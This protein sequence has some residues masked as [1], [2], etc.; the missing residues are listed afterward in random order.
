MFKSCYFLIMTLHIFDEWFPAEFN[1]KNCCNI[2]ILSKVIANIP[3]RVGWWCISCVLPGILPHLHLLLYLMEE[4]HQ[5]G[6][7]GLSWVTQTLVTSPVRTFVHLAQYSQYL[8]AISFWDFRLIFSSPIWR[9]QEI[10]FSAWTCEDNYVV[11]SQYWVL[12]SASLW[13]CLHRSK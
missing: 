7:A 9:R 5:V 10:S 11:F 2:T 1:E 13:F 12:A 4:V 8:L 3:A 6:S